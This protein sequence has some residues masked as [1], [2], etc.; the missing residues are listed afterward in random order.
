MRNIKRVVVFLT[1]CFALDVSSA[2]YNQASQPWVNAKLQEL[3]NKLTMAIQDTNTKLSSITNSEELSR[4]IDSSIQ[5]TTS[6]SAAKFSQLKS[7]YTPSTNDFVFYEG[8]FVMSHS[9]EL[10]DRFSSNPSVTNCIE[11]GTI[12]YKLDGSDV[13]ESTNGLVRLERG[14][15]QDSLKIGYGSSWTITLTKNRE[16]T[17]FVLPSDDSVSVGVISGQFIK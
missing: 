12:L 14:A 1:M 8:F 2:V 4:E 7:V 16:S 10:S 13:Y 9:D 15:T 3:E 6:I 17:R 11:Y 5:L